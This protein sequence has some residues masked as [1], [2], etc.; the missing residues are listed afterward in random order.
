MLKTLGLFFISIFFIA[1]KKVYLIFFKKQK[2]ETFPGY[3]LLKINTNY[4]KFFI[5]TFN[6]PV[7]FVTGTNGKTSTTHLLNYLILQTKLAV[8]T[9]LSGSNLKRGVLSSVVLNYYKFLFN[10]PDLL[11]FEVDEGFV[12]SVAKDFSCI[13]KSKYILLLNLSRDQLDRYGEVDTLVQKINKAAYDFNFKIIADKKLYPTLLKPHLYPVCTGYEKT[14]SK[15]KIESSSH[16]KTNFCFIASVLNDL[17]ISIPLG[18]LSPFES[19][20]GRGKNFE[21]KGCVYALNLSKNPASF[22]TSLIQQSATKNVLILLNDNIPDGRDVSWIY[23]I[24]TNLLKDFLKDKTVCVAGTRSFDFINL[25][26]MLNIPCFNFNTFASYSIFATKT[27]IK[28]TF[29]L[30]N[31]S[32]T[33]HILK[34]Y[35]K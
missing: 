18:K 26:N 7:I 13:S 5:S 16:L 30:A 6:C 9:N 24:D 14:L 27:Y 8:L 22:N 1:S 20:P 3:F 19:V 35:A 12:Y 4:L 17:N 31:Y 10:K 32:A 34:N 2:F 28:N 29:I 15:L 23:D 33:S 11:I 25:L 21:Y